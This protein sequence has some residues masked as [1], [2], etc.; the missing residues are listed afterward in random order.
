MASSGSFSTN[1]YT[2]VS[3]GTPYL[4][5][6]W[7][8]VGSDSNN[9]KHTIHYK[10]VG[11]GLN[12][13][14]YCQLHRFKL[15]VNGDT[16]N[17]TADI[18]IA[19]YNDTVIVEGDKDIYHEADGSKT[20]SA[21]IVA[22]FYS[23]NVENVSGSNSWELDK[24]ER[25][26]TISIS[27]NSKDIN[28]IK[29]NW[30][31]NATISSAKYSIDNG[32]NYSAYKGVNAKSGTV[33]I[34]NLEPNTT[35]KIKI[36]IKRAD[37]SL[38]TTS[39]VLTIKTY[40]YAKFTNLNNSNFADSIEIS[41]NNESSLNNNLELLINDEIILS[42]NN[43]TNNYNLIFTQEELDKIYKKYGNSNTL[44]AKYKLITVC[45]NISYTDTQE[46]NI[47]LTGNAKTSRLNINNTNKRA[48]VYISINGVIKEA[49]VWV[50]VNGTPKR[51]I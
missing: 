28:S 1:A 7:N 44:V 38:E 27:E 2:G 51:C 4:E 25:Y 24:F 43:I 10:V 48:K 39:S 36:R 21:S 14:Q 26:A 22:G 31:S 13:Y 37:N 18:S 41:K 16:I 33:T 19:T 5:F 49:I 8:V 29:V 42:R 12:A 30:S 11:K 6:T 32:V 9:N 23:Y 50:G 3:V 45:N 20:F 40:D 46:K 47:V 35:Y 17:D 34:D 15:V